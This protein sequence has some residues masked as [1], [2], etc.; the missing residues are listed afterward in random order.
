MSTKNVPEGGN[1]M[2]S[3]ESSLCICS[4]LSSVKLSS[5]INS[6]G[7]CFKSWNKDQRKK[8]KKNKSV[9]IHVTFQSRRNVTRTL[10]WWKI[11]EKPIFCCCWQFPLFS[12]LW[13]RSILKDRY[14]TSG[15]FLEGNLDH[16]QSVFYFVPQ[17][18]CESHSQAGWTRGTLKWAPI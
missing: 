3:A 8:S 16:S 2:P 4:Y 6:H 17:E 14:V 18:N 12:Q 9:K 10:W 11:G 7:S 5:A 15:T 1:G 13:K